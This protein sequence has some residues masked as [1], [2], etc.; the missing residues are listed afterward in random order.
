MDNVTEDHKEVKVLHIVGSVTEAVYS[1]LGPAAEVL[2]EAGFSQTIVMLDE[3]QH[4]HLQTRFPKAIRLETVPVDARS[5]RHWFVM[6]KVIQKLI[7]THHYSAI[8]LHGFLPWAFGTRMGRL[9]PRHTR[10]YYSPHGSRTLTLLRPLQAMLGSVM[11]LLGTGPHKVIASSGAD[12]QRVSSADRKRPVLTIE[13]AIDDTFFELPRQEAR[14]PLLVSGDPDDNNRSVEL[15]CRL[16]VVLSAAEL[17]LSFNWIG[18]LDPVSAARLKAANVGSFAISDHKEMAARLAPGWI[19]VAAGEADEFPIL[20]AWAMALGLPCVV[21]DTAHHRDLITHGGNG[22]IYR[23]EEEALAQVS[24][25]IDSVALRTELGL[26]ARAEAQRRLSQSKLTD[27][28]LAAYRGGPGRNG[29][30]VPT[31]SNGLPRHTH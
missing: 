25:L 14:R 28:L 8:H 19:F 15:F 16:A 17:G 27:A 7:A 2:S 12:A 23:S 10:V 29:T 24:K 1:F 30:P 21:S 20:L 5:R 26:A 4:R 31:P 6:T 13:G 18:Q 3:P 11:S 9:I 22:L